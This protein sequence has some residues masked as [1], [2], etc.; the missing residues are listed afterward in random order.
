MVKPELTATYAKRI[1]HTELN[2]S[3]KVTQVVKVVGSFETVL[4]A[5]P[6]YIALYTLSLVMNV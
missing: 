5:E 3:Y 6:N 2:V 1:V 4:K